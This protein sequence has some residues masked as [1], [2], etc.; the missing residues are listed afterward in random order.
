M[1]EGIAAGRGARKKIKHRVLAGLVAEGVNVQMVFSITEGAAAVLA[2]RGMKPQ[3]DAEVS[4]LVKLAKAALAEPGGENSPWRSYQ[5]FDDIVDGQG[6]VCWRDPDRD[7]GSSDLEGRGVE[8]CTAVMVRP[9]NEPHVG[10]TGSGSG[11]PASIIQEAINEKA[12]LLPEYRKTGY[13]EQWLLVVGSDG[14][15]GSLDVSDAEGEFT[16]PFERT[17]FLESFENVC[18]ELRARHPR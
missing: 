15:G 10:W 13:E 12:A 4:S 6:T 14:T 16:S 11:Q 2:T 9:M 3:L 8:F 17:F 5:W 1:D 7:R 18:V